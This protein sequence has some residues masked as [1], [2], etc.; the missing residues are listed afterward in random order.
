[1][2]VKQITQRKH[3]KSATRYTTSITKYLAAEE[4]QKVQ[5]EGKDTVPNGVLYLQ[6]HVTYIKYLPK[7]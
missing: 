3:E 1:M 7:P 4:T 5:G 6:E 2:D